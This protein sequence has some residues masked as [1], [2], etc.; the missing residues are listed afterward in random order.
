[1]AGKDT[2]VEREAEGEAGR[3]A[4]GEAERELGSNTGKVGEGEHWKKR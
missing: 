4:E 1:M 2:E 3:E